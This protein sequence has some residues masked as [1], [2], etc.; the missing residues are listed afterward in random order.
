VNE[1]D[2]KLLDLQSAL[3]E[4]QR[5][6]EEN[7][8]LRGLLQEHGIQLPVVQSPN[9]IPVRTSTQPITHTPVLKAEQ[10]IALFRSLFHGR[11]DV[12]AVRWENAD[13]RSGYMPKADRDWKAYLR[14][15]DKDRKKVDRQTRKFRP[16]TDEVVRGHLVGDNTVGISAAAG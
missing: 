7:V 2:P 5:L 13:G 15:K 3:A 14:A 9:G 6:R 1:S 12:Y 8:R 10:R 11:D 4:V 16:L